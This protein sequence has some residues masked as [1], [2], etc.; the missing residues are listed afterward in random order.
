MYNHEYIHRWLD[1]QGWQ[2]RLCIRPATEN[3]VGAY[4]EITLADDVVE[5]LSHGRTMPQQDPIGMVEAMTM[6]IVVHLDQLSGTI[7]LTYLRDILAASCLIV[8]S[9]I[10]LNTFELTTDMGGGGAESS[11]YV[12]AVCGQKPT[13]Q[14]QV[15]L[16]GAERYQLQIAAIDLL[17]LVAEMTPVP[18]NWSMP[19]D[20]A[21]ESASID[22][23]RYL[24]NWHMVSARQIHQVADTTL[25]RMRAL[26]PAMRTVT[27]IVSKLAYRALHRQDVVWSAMD[28][29]LASKSISPVHAGWQLYRYDYTSNDLA[30]KVAVTPDQVYYIADTGVSGLERANSQYSPAM[31]FDNWW[32]MLIHDAE[33]WLAKGRT[34]WRRD[35][36]VVRPCV[37]YQ[38]AFNDYLLPGLLTGQEVGELIGTSV[39]FGVRVLRSATCQTFSRNEDNDA[40]SIAD[41]TEFQRSTNLSIVDEEYGVKELTFDPMPESAMPD[42]LGAWIGGPIPYPRME[43]YWFCTLY[44]AVSA[45]AWARIHH[46]VQHSDGWSVTA[47]PAISVSLPFDG[48]PLTGDW[49]GVIADL[50]KNHGG[51]PMVVARAYYAALG[52]RNQSHLTGGAQAKAALMPMEIGGVFQLNAAAEIDAML[53]GLPLQPAVL[54]NSVY[55]HAS[56]EITATWFIRGSEEAL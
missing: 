3:S 28:A 1:T 50:Q 15:N 45:G 26:G 22:G 25:L 39:E 5:V 14:R 35:G 54:V 42:G 17:K 41:L 13:L 4:T 2:W 47:S 48:V 11:W 55:D 38:S 56:D 32:E 8:G 9:E 20:D 52:R 30:E 18:E 21:Q 49:P 12:A 46:S 36:A 27:R 40:G 34:V 29:F 33:S 37:E 44:H 43:R 53:A 23:D 16:D 24:W 19:G 6:D 31:R 51:W 10:Y 7:E